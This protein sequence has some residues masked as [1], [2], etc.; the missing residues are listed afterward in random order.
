MLKGPP[1][2]PKAEGMCL[3]LTVI[4]SGKDKDPMEIRIAPIALIE[5]DR[6]L[7]ERALSLVKE[8]TS[9]QGWELNLK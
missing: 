8:L 1:L 5:E 2:N 7:G 9:D 3:R 4:L 6:D